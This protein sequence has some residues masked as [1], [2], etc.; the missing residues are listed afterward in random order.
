[1]T[2]QELTKKLKTEK[3]VAIVTHVRPDGDAV[4]SALA[5]SSALKKCGVASDVFCDDSVPQKFFYL[6]GAKDVS[7]ASCV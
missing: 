5:L 2:L 4:G 7:V 6:A 3:A 1:M